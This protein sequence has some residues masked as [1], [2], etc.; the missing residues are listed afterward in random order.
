MCCP[1][2]TPS[3]VGV[4][5]R[6]LRCLGKG[7][8]AGAGGEGGG[9]AGR[10][11]SP[12]LAGCR[13]PPRSTAQSASPTRAP[14]LMLRSCRQLGSVDLSPT[15][16]SEVLGRGPCPSR[17]GWRGV[18]AVLRGSSQRLEGGQP[19]LGGRC[20]GMDG[21]GQLVPSR[22]QT[23]GKGQRAE[24]AEQ[25]KKEPGSSSTSLSPRTGLC[26]KCPVFLIYCHI[27]KLPQTLRLKTTFVISVSAGR[28]AGCE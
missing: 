3:S 1:Q 11:H 8:A 10:A 13:V 16:E 21:R 15:P 27:N 9:G 18:K 7:Q 5:R 24:D 6:V 28:G 23:R 14:V 4:G 20:V 25:K 12:G 26:Q 22:G 2:I 19:A 17:A